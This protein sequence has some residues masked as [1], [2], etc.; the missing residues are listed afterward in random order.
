MK[1][2]IT[3]FCI[4]A[5]VAVAVRADQPATRPTT[6]NDVRS[7]ERQPGYEGGGG[8]RMG[9]GPRR[10]AEPLPTDAEWGEISAFMKEHSPERLN[11][12]NSLPDGVRRDNLKILLNR[13]YKN[14]QRI[15][16][17]QPEV[18]QLMIKRLDLEDRVFKLANDVRAERAHG[19]PR[20]NSDK[21]SL[22]KTVGDWIDASFKEREARVARLKTALADEEDKLERDRA[23][24]EQLVQ[25]R[26]KNFLNGQRADSRIMD[27]SPVDPR[28]TEDRQT[29]TTQP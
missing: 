16:V 12:I 21:Q 18:G 23:N 26:L 19:D 15:K 6:P 8:R 4:L 20:L 3:G 14:F 10:L 1:L 29:P 2:W 28:D 25:I 22:E 7:F 24:R 5:F 27:A 17:D 13:E 11:A 9:G